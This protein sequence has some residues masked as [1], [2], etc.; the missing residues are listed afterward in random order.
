MGLLGITEGWGFGG[1]GAGFWGVGWWGVWAA[2][3]HGG[4]PCFVG[5]WTAVLVGLLFG[6]PLFM[7]REDLHGRRVDRFKTVSSSRVG[8]LGCSCYFA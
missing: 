5:L 2:A 4:H 1:L 8:I 6:V 7:G 3:Y